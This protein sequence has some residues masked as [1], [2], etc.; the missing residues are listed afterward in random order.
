[1]TI[2]GRHISSLCTAMEE[3]LQGATAV[4]LT[5]YAECG[6]LLQV[7]GPERALSCASQQQTRCSMVSV[8]GVASAQEAARRVGDGR[9]KK[10]MGAC[11]HATLTGA[12][13]AERALAHESRRGLLDG[14][15]HKDDVHEHERRI[16]IG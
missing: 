11:S 10:P 16:A 7:L 14:R 2:E 3:C 13:A 9:G 12:G 8:A 6:L 15:C 5:G 4:A 1:M